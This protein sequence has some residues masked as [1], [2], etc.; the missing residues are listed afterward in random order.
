MGFKN[1]VTSA[2]TSVHKSLQ[3]LI[4]PNINYQKQHS[5]IWQ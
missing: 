3:I 5:E 1:Q 4:Q 2:K